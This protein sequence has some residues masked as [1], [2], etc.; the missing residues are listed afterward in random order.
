MI[1]SITVEDMT[2]KQKRNNLKGIMEFIKR[3]SNFVRNGHNL[4][5]HHHLHY[6]G[7]GGSMIR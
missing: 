4:K 5:H 1:I 2:A 3:I 7:D 6:Y